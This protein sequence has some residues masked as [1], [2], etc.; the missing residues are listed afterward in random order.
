MSREASQ[1]RW[2][3]RGI[4]SATIALLSV[5]ALSL[6]VHFT[7]GWTTLLAPWRA[8]TSA[9][10]AVLLL[11][12]ALSY[13]VRAARLYDYFHDTVAGAPLAVLRLSLLHNL[14]NNL[15]PMRSGEAAF[16]L[17]MKRYFGATY[18]QSGISLLWL[19]LLDLAALTLLAASTVMMS[20]SLGLGPRR[21]ALA[22]ALASVIALGALP[23]LARRLP[24]D[25][26]GGTLRRLMH[27]IATH[28]PSTA[29]AYARA[30][31]YTLLAWAAKGFA[32]VWLA[33]QFTALATG[34]A[35]VGVAAGELSS[36]L[37]IHG[38]AGSGT[39]EGAM[40][41]AL[42][43]V[44]TDHDLALLAAVNV[45]L[46]LLGVAIALGGLAL[47]LPRPSPERHTDRV[48]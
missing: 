3:G 20:P 18:V 1:G 40:V 19:R 2:T 34:T 23:W 46:F 12:M 47:A 15:L 14:V 42:V 9:D 21:V 38:L 44:G 26:R 29:S 41:G 24:A 25:P 11:A 5:P 35:A 31:V 7:V 8:L 48:S 17:L 4:L 45:H 32:F 37:P 22:L 10:L 33:V 6:W 43:A 16:P 39:Y 28:L 13:A 27:T 30:V 36:V